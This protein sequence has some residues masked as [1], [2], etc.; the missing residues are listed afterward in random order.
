[1]QTSTEHQLGLITKRAQVLEEQLGGQIELVR[2]LQADRDAAAAEVDDLRA[3]LD[4]AE[5]RASRVATEHDDAAVALKATAN[6]YGKAQLLQKRYRNAVAEQAG[7]CRAFVVVRAPEDAVAAASSSGGA[8]ATTRVAFPGALVV[9]DDCTINL[10][11]KWQR[12]LV[13]DGAIAVFPPPT[14][15]LSLSAAAADALLPAVAD[16]A[17]SD[18]ISGYNASLVCFGPPGQLKASLMFGDQPSSAGGTGLVQRTMRRL[19]QSLEGHRVTH[20]SMRM[21]MG[22]V[23]APDDQFKDLLSEYSN[24]LTLGR[25][26][27]VRCIPVQGESEALS[28]VQLGMQRAAEA[29]RGGT[30][31]GGGVGAGSASQPASAAAHKFVVLT[32]ENF[33]TR[34]HFRKGTLL[35]VDI[36]AAP[37]LGGAAAV[38]GRAGAGAHVSYYQQSN[39]QLWAQQSS[40]RFCDTVAYLA[41]GPSAAA[42]A[43]GAGRAPFP[44]NASGL[45]LLL[46]ESLG[47]NSKTALITC[48]DSAAVVDPETRDAADG[49][50]GALNVALM[51]KSIKN[52]ALP[53]DVPAELQRLNLESEGFA[54]GK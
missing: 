10:P 49:T 9:A 45:M 20:Y 43:G 24:V 53:F 26:P 3:R 54:G 22:E 6:E 8:H 29:H 25:S 46:G 33:D 36:A 34:G 1:M 2:R 35:F 42:V 48:I 27:D 38:P 50:V 51:L 44:D 39:E 52:S 7:Y 17:I 41:G 15:A 13:L 37:V 12:S 11:G 32:I 21:S 31:G 16:A 14:P 23:T 47:G 19:F 18:V 5:R 30:G 28:L 4:A 40:A